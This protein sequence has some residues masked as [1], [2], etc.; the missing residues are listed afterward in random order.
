MSK[1]NTENQVKKFYDELP[2]NYYGELDGQCKAIINNNSIFSY[3]DLDNLL[4]GKKIKSIIDIG[5]GSGWFANSIAFYYGI[6]VLGVDFSKK[7]IE[8]AKKV[9]KV[10]KLQDIAKFK[11]GNF[12][13]LPKNIGKFS[14][15]N[16]IGVLHHTE[17]C[18]KSLKIISGLVES[19]GYIHIGLY[20]KYGRKPFLDM[21]KKQRK[22]IKNNEKISKKE[23]GDAFEKYKKLN[24]GINDEN[25]LHSWF[26][27][28]VLHVHETQHTFKEI[29]LLLN[30]LGFEVISS[31]INN[32]KKISNSDKLFE[33]EKKYY[34]ISLERNLIKG[35]YFPGFFTILAKKK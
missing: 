5:C 35:Q 34:N 14:L 22:K 28:Q 30:R 1:L 15:V 8:R 18:L 19:E 16:S 20:H 3:P 10:L 2:F 23:M 26:R 4:K 33:L 13:N 27:D 12:L 9:S 29:F 32:F 17:N 21:F 24:K 25:F 6:N 11:Y 7:A 31:S